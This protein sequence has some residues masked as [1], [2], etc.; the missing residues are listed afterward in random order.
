MKFNI[1]TLTICDIKACV[2]LS[3]GN[4]YFHDNSEIYGWDPCKRIIRTRFAYN[5]SEEAKLLR[6][7][8]ICHILSLFKKK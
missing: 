2:C 3:V 1:F 4:E 7:R 6:P 5:I 8:Q